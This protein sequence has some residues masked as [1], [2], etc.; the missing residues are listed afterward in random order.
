[1][2]A[3]RIGIRG[4]LLAAYALTIAIVTAVELFAQDAASKAG[5]EFEARL[6]RHYSIQSLRAALSEFR[7]LGERYMR[8][9]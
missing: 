3:P 6:A 9:R 4:K 1:M 5:L 8:E 7:S 2:A